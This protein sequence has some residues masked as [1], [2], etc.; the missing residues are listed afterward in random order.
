MHCDPAYLLNKVLER[1]RVFAVL[2]T[3]WSLWSAYALIGFMQFILADGNNTC[4]D[5]HAYREAGVAFTLFGSTII[6]V[7]LA[8][9][10]LVIWHLRLRLDVHARG[11]TMRRLRDEADNGDFRSVRRDAQFAIN[12]LFQ[13]PKL[14]AVLGWIW[15][16]LSF[17]S[18][19]VFSE[20]LSQGID[21][22]VN[23]D[24]NQRS[25]ESVLLVNILRSLPLTIQFSM[26]WGFKL[27]LSVMSRI[28]DAAAPA[29]P[30]SDD[31]VM[32][33]GPMIVGGGFP[34]ASAEPKTGMQDVTL[35]GMREPPVVV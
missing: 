6:D 23:V 28:P 11:H 27:E 26:L 20:Y 21:C 33:E 3:I 32:T 15:V 5:P 9:Q 29:N 22:G 4:N 16:L 31:V 35:A 30:A 10:Y 19:Q 2:E 7:C 25:V 18:L 13:H 34:N 17:A 14:W 1:H 24:F 12:V 8:V